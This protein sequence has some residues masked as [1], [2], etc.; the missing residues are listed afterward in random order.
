MKF[1]FKYLFFLFAV[2]FFGLAGSAY[3]ASDLGSLQETIGVNKTLAVGLNPSSTGSWYVGSVAD[4]S[5]ASAVI[6]GNSLVV[7]GKSAG[8]TKILACTDSGAQHC[9]EVNITVSSVLGAFTE[10]PHAVKSWVLN[11]GTVFYV[12]INGLIPISTWK[13]FLSNKGH[14][15]LIKPANSADLALPLEP[16]MV[17]RDPRVK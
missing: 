8:T 17:P 7:S 11:N 5:I 1:K 6:N 12:D 13:I 9:L 3:A 15:K 10:Q 4:L 2:S 14:A 16:L